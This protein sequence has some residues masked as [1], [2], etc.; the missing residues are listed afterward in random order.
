LTCTVGDLTNG[1][2]YTFT[3]TARNAAI[4]SLTADPVSVGATPRTV[5]DAPTGLDATAGDGSVELEW[6]A[7]EYDG[8]SEITGYVVEYVA[9]E[10]Q[11]GEEAD[12]ITLDPGPGSDTTEVT[13]APL[14]NGTKYW[15]RVAAVN[16]AGRGAFSD[17]IA[18]TPED[19][20]PPD[21]DEGDD[22]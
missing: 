10:S 21:E 12:W 18:S 20:A 9:A 6:V 1:T 11:P 2:A 19:P 8:G 4:S 5:P 17:P 13:I 15:F 22:G 3:V 16:G 7:P 14:T